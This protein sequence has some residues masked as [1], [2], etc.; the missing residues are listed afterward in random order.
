MALT[1][2]QKIGVGGIC[3]FIFSFLFSGVILPP[4]VKHEVKKKVALKQGWM[5]REVWGKFPFSF[6]FHFYMFNVTNHMDIKGGA[7]PIVAE[8]GPFVYEEWKEKVNQVDHDE[9]DTISYNAKSTFIFNAEKSKGLTG[10]EEVIMPHFFILGTVNSVLRDKASAMPIVSKALDSIFRKPDSIFVKAKVREIL[11]DG[12]VIDCNVKDFAGSAVC[13]EI[14]QNYEEFRLQS[15]GDN[16]YSLSLFGLINGTEN[17]ARHRVKRGLK[18]IMEVGKVVEYDGK[19]NV[20]VW[21]NEICDAFNGSD[22]SVFHPYFD[23]KGKD[24]LVAFNAD[25]CRSV[26]CHYDSDTKFAGLKLLRY[27]TDLGT[28]VEKY[29][30][31]KCYCVTPDRCPKKGAMDIFK[32]VNAPIMITNPHFYLADPWYVSAIEGVKPDREK[33]MIMID[34]DPFTGS[35]IHVHTRAQ[36]NMFLQPVE[37]FKL[38]KTFP[39]ALLP[40]IWFD[41]ILILPDFL[42]KEIKGGHR[43]VAM[44]KVFKFLMMFGG[45]GMAGYAGFMHYKA[46]QGENT[47]EVKKVPVKSSPNGVGSGEKKINISTIQPAPLPPNVD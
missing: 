1:K 38:M 28:D 40:L 33:H 39:N 41:E 45:L 30:H 29:P 17:K 15:I 7:K 13:N 36:F 8:V 47:T 25:L 11:F 43:Q 3:M 22:G 20:S 31:H 19:N 42:L 27:T 44:A 12:I 26:I 14:A 34:I 37:K 46:T 16:K 2:I 32:C 4:I 35:P 18:N 23:K 5:M 21:D 10:E 9:D 24:D 6:E